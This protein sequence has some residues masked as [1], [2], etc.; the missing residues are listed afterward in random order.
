MKLLRPF[1]DT[2]K[3]QYHMYKKEMTTIFD[4]AFSSERQK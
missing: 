3:Y 2:V 4:L 1:T